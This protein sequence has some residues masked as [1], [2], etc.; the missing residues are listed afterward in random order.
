MST[1]TLTACS[2]G[3][4]PSE[5]VADAVDV[6]EGVCEGAT[7]RLTAD[8]VDLAVAEAVADDD[9]VRVARRLTVVDDWADADEGWDADAD[10]REVAVTDSESVSKKDGTVAAAE[11]DG[12]SDA[13]GLADVLVELEPEKVTELDI[14]D[15]EDADELPEANVDR[16]GNAVTSDDGE[17]GVV[18]VAHTEREAEL[19]AE[20][21]ATDADGS[22]DAVL[23]AIDDGVNND[24]ALPECDD[25]DDADS[26]ARPESEDDELVLALRGA[27]ALYP[28]ERVGWAVTESCIVPVD[29]DVGVN[30]GVAEGDVMDTVAVWV[31]VAVPHDDADKMADAVPLAL[32]EADGVID[33]EPDGLTDALARLV[34]DEE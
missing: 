32:A 30:D 28:G 34:T 12:I 33:V 27:D 2:I 29:S 3:R 21:D 18:A 11:D 5:G 13:D 15:L 8:V 10:S 26:V 22:L 4:M 16:E 25:A 24:E 14:V 17:G 9:E 7:F 23:V 31:G 19:L 6:R 20:R 1:L